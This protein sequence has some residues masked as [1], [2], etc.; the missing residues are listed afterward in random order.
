MAATKWCLLL[1]LLQAATIQSA[2]VAQDRLLELVHKVKSELHDV[3]DHVVQEAQDTTRDQLIQLMRSASEQQEQTDTPAVIGAL[4]LQMDV[5]NVTDSLNR[6]MSIPTWQAM[7]RALGGDREILKR[8]AQ[9]RPSFAAME[10]QLSHGSA[11]DQLNQL[12]FEFES[13]WTRLWPQLQTLIETVSNLHDWFDR[14]QRNSAVVN[15]RT[16]RDY[17]DTVHGSDGLTTAKALESIHK[18]TCPEQPAP[19][20]YVD[21]DIER[22]NST[23][24]SGGAFDI[25]KNA[26]LS[27]QQPLTSYPFRN[28]SYPL[29]HLKHDSCKLDQFNNSYHNAYLFIIF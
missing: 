17:A 11:E 5:L 27:V 13:P 2:M 23:V 9:L 18:A 16:L 24:C 3:K 10:K 19:S 28:H 14:Y 25:L 7:I 1:L 12:S 26:T 8:F 4:A 15:E 6:E 29:I 21:D 22:E 20:Q